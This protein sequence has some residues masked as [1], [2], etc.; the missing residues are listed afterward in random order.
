MDFFKKNWGFWLTIIFFVGLS[1]L[2]I[3]NLYL[4]LLVFIFLFPFTN[5]GFIAKAL[6]FLD[7]LYFILL[8]LMILLSLIVPDAPL[9]EDTLYIGLVI[10]VW[11]WVG[12]AALTSAIDDDVTDK[13][14]IVYFVLLIATPFVCSAV[15]T[16]VGGA[17]RTILCWVVGLTTLSSVISIFNL[18]RAVGLDS[19]SSNSKSSGVKTAHFYQVEAAAESAAS[20]CNCRVKRVEKSGRGYVIQLDNARDS[21][22]WSDSSRDFMEYMYEELDGYDVGEIR[23]IY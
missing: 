1:V 6:F 3:E 12:L 20:R 14:K 23:V 17:L 5:R 4:S 18:P 7:F 10:T 22:G 19:G 21:Y 15:S 9:F 11:S 2:N 8:A 16:F 13:G